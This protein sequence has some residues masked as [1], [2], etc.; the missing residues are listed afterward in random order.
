MIRVMI[1]DDEQSALDRYSDY[2]N[3]SGL[4]FSV[5]ATYT[6]A[7]GALEAVRTINPDVVLTD[8]R[9]PGKNGLR[10]IEDMRAV[11]WDGHAVVISGHDDFEFA[12]EAMRLQMVDYLLKPIF[13][14]DMNELLKRLRQKE[15]RSSAANADLLPNVDWERVPGFVRRTVGYVQAN[16]EHHLSLRDAAEHASVNP[17]YLSTAFSHHCGVSFLDFCHRVRVQAAR[18]LLHSSDLTLADIAERVGCSDASHL[19]RLFRKVTGETPGR[20]RS[21]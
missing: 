11:G 14:D 15:F 16:Y 4:G 7:Q 2:V 10:M 13:P 8:I 12:R 3:A 20:F 17:T 21:Y 9:M 18:E 1:V 19:N 6:G 5:V